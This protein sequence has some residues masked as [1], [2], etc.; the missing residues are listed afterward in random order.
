MQKFHI[1]SNGDVKFCAATKNACQFGDE[2]L[3]FSSVHEACAAAESILS[4][5]EG[6]TQALQGKKRD[7]L[8]LQIK[9]ADISK[10]PQTKSLLPLLGKIPQDLDEREREFTKTAVGGSHHEVSLGSTPRTIRNYFE[11]SLRADE[12][13]RSVL[14]DRNGNYKAISYSKTT[15][16]FSVWTARPTKEIP[17]TMKIVGG[18]N[19]SAH[20]AG[21]KITYQCSQCKRTDSERLRRFPTQRQGDYRIRCRYCG[22]LGTIPLS[23]S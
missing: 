21:P 15:D 11:R 4:S 22:Q 3:H 17:L 2:T 13:L 18:W 12:K 9:A 19:M 8:S 16:E 20:P 23:Y 6:N 10:A 14:R 1:N 7:L 5:A